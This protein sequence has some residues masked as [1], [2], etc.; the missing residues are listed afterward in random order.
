[1]SNTTAKSSS[2]AIEVAA[3]L[4]S[5]VVNVKHCTD[6]GAGKTSKKTLA[7]FATGA[8]A[9]LASAVSFGSA[10]HTATRNEQGLAYTTK[11]QH[12]PARA[13]RAEQVSAASDVVTAGGAL[14]GIGALA[15]GLARARR[16]RKDPSYRIGTAP[17][18]EL[19]LDTAPAADY[20]LV[21]AK[22]DEFVFTYSPAIGGDMTTADGRTVPLAQLAQSAGVPSATV[23]GATELPI[24]ANARIRATSG[25]ATFIVAAVP[26]PVMPAAP[27]LALDKRLLGYAAASLAAHLG[28]LAILR[29]MPVD[30]SSANLDLAAQEGVM[31]R[32][33]TTDKEDPTKETQPDDGGDHGAGEGT[34]EAAKMQLEEGAAGKPSATADGRIQIKKTSDDPAIARQQAIEE[35]RTAGILGSTRALDDSIRA[36]TGTADLSSGADD[37]N[38]WG[39]I[40]GGD[41]EGHGVFGFG[42]HGLG[43]GGGCLGPN[44]GLVG[45]G[46]YHTIPGGGGDGHDY[47]G[48]IGDGPGH[49]PHVAGVPT[50]HL[51]EPVPTPGLDKAIIARYMKRHV[52]EFQYCYEKQLL[53]NPDLAGSVTVNFFIGS[54]G[55]VQSATATG[56]DPTVASCVATVTKG[57]AFPKP[58]DAGGVQVNYPF[59]FHRAGQ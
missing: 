46:N 26:R 25:Q 3:M 38:Q 48:P 33:Q 36:I 21:A 37:V 16:E 29:A 59:T 15:A 44:C 2:T 10:V 53:A 35:A 18:V 40:Y 9:L 12:K 17:G 31:T 42:R 32:V 6:P 54:D 52:N 13:F 7:M 34:R 8:A 1:M 19:P 5:S 30:D 51:G 4:G 22:G 14:V 23:P 47:R 24:P 57:V 20:P 49:R 45:T 58:G 39:S 43:P 27:L 28:V 55:T 11:V 56:F 41:G 50:A